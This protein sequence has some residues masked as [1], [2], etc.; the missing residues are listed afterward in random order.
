MVKSHL[1]LLHA[2]L[3]QT[4]KIN[5]FT[6]VNLHYFLQDTAHTP[7]S[8]LS[9]HSVVPAHLHV[10]P[11]AQFPVVFL[12]CQESR[13]GADR[14]DGPLHL[15]ARLATAQSR[16]GQPGGPLA[17]TQGS[18]GTGGGGLGGLGGLRCLRVRMSIEGKKGCP[19]GI[20]QDIACHKAPAGQTPHGSHEP[21]WGQRSRLAMR[22]L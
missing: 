14:V 10:N 13:G 4:A 22:F 19:V 11:G 15:G 7:N 16:E 18:G 20:K 6:N 5:L 21:G 8:Q 2:F 9:S 3:V 1:C 12:P 17:L